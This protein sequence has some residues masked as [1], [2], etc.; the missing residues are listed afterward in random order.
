MQDIDQ[1]YKVNILIQ[2]KNFKEAEKYLK[3]ML[4]QDPNNT[5]MLTLLAEIYL[6]QD[7][8][9]AANIIVDQAIALSPESA[10]L[11]STKS[12]I[13]IQ[14]DKIEEAE[15]YNLQALRLDPYNSMHYAIAASIK[16]NNKSFDLALEMANKALELDAENILALNI[17]TSALTKLNRKEEAFNT[18]DG[19]LREDPNNA[20]THANYGWNLLE[21]GDHK[22]ALEHFKEA[23]TIDP[24]FE[25]AQAGIL[26]AIK[27][28]NFFYRMYL[29]YAFWM[30]NKVAKHQ[31]SII[32]GVFVFMKLIQYITKTNPQLGP[33]LN[34]IIA[35]LSIFAFSTWII[36]PI[37]NL[38]LRF[39]KYGKYLL[40][41]KEKISSNFVA[42]SFA[43]S[44]AGLLLYFIFDDLRF[45]PIAVLGL[46]MMLPF[47]VMLTSD[48]K[49]NSMI[50]LVA[51]LSLVGL[52]AVFRTFSTGIVVNF[53]SMVFI[54]FFVGFQWIAN[55][56]LSK[57]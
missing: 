48:K 18:I 45:I 25:L 56:I 6:Q 53:F 7:K 38:F 43:T 47:S 52:L 33:F 2:Q 9:E 19:A 16:L 28:K 15:R 49:K 21:K 24:N 55:Y 26:Q 11:F 4:S 39:N 14:E 57:K 42:F 29:K 40:D 31:W 8:Y 50:T 35:I 41:R 27:S 44:I 5:N 37:G 20:F 54:W 22:K 30:S 36:S 32:I 23:L 10:D 1:L 34:P 46:A 17:R 3:E 13:A 12:R 51:A